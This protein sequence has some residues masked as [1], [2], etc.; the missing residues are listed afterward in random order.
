MCTF[1]WDCEFVLA[2]AGRGEC[3]IL[4]GRVLLRIASRLRTRVTNR[5]SGYGS[6]RIVG[7]VRKL[8]RWRVAARWSGNSSWRMAYSA[9]DKGDI[10]GQVRLA[11]IGAKRV[12]DSDCALL[13]GC[14]ACHCLFRGNQ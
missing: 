12:I 2:L 14:N 7:R 11:V 6:M 10:D 4:P 9:D 5:G 8:P 1:I 13:A 3:P